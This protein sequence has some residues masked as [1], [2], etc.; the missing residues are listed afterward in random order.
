MKEER[1]RP[2]NKAA[3]DGEGGDDPSDAMERRVRD[4]MA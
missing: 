4:G 1:T 2:K 3:P